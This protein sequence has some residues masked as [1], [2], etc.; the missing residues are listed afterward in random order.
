MYIKPGFAFSEIMD[1]GNWLV[2][3]GLAL[4]IAIPFFATVN[5]K[6]DTAYRIPTMIDYYDPAVYEM[7]PD[8]PAFEASSKRSMEDYQAALAARRS[9]PV[10][11]D[12]FLSF[13]SFDP[14][15][16]YRPALAISLFYVPLVIL[17]VSIFSGLASFGLLIRR[18]YAVLATCTLMA[19]AAAHLPFAIAGIA[20]FSS[21]IDP[22]IHF[23]MWIASGALFGIFMLFAIRT[24]LGTTFAM[25]ALAVALA[26][27]AFSLSMYVFQYVSPWLLSPFLLLFAFIYLGGYIGGEVRGFGNAFR[28][29]Q[30]LKRFS[31]KRDREPKRRRRTRAARLDI[32]GKASGGAGDRTSDKGDRDR[33]GGDRRELRAWQ[34][35]TATRRATESARSFRGR[36]GT[37]R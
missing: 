19:W 13:F 3:A 2:A 27:P 24:V 31:S 18:D 12:R 33:P 15:A 17:L 23:A 32:S 29:R 14:T 28:Q 11:G 7:E 20:L 30:N 1:R 36:V 8:S 35:C 9:V 10:F 22:V 25:A 34:N 6:L 5:A 21:E 4:L 16:F 37:K 26:W